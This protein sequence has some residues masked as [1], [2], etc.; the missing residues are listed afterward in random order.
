MKVLPKILLALTA[1]LTLSVAYPAKANLITNPGFETGNFTGWSVSGLAGV[2]GTVGGLSPHSGNFQALLGSN[3]VSISQSVATTPGQS[4]TIDF[5]AAS[6]SPTNAPITLTV[7][8]GGTVFSHIFTA[9]TGYTEFMFNATVPSSAA[10]LNFTTSLPVVFLD[11]V[12]VT[13]TGVGVPD[14]GTTVSLLGCALVGLA[15]LRR[16]LGC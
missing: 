3:N 10:S 15:G 11:D 13:P 14:G 2:D 8:F 1:V 9:N 16:K 12:S 7:N 5:F 6:T 4:Y